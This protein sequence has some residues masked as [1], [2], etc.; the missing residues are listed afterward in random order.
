MAEKNFPY[1]ETLK[2]KAY[3]RFPL[4]TRGLPPPEQNCCLTPAQGE[5]YDLA[6]T[7]ESNRRASWN[8]RIRQHGSGISKEAA[9]GEASQR[10][11]KVALRRK[12]D[13]NAL[14]I[15]KA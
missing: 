6:R 13:A 5:A 14:T 10:K 9:T 2:F 1:P 12:P 3:V 8:N 15:L 4:L 7:P 11:L